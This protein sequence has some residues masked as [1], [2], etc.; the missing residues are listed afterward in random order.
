MSVDMKLTVPDWVADAIFYQIFPDRFCNGEKRNDPPGL[1]VWGD[2]PT[3]EN[4]FGGDL[5]GILIRLDYLQNL[6]VNALYLNPIFQARTNHRY[7]TIDY[8]KV[9]PA[10]G[11]TALLK[12]LV[13]QVH[14]RGMHIILDGVFNHCGDGFAPFQ[15]VINKG[16][17]SEYANWFLARS[18]PL[19]ID[20]LNFRTCGGC[21][22]LPKLNLA[23]RPVQEFILK[24]ACYW[25]EET[26]MDGWRLDVPFK[27][28]LDFWRKFRQ[29]VK[30]AN[31]Q[32]YLV[33]EVWREAAPWIAGDCFD[34][35]TNYRLRDLVLG[36]VLTHDFDGEDI[37]FELQTLLTA[38]GPA[39]QSMLNLLDSHDTP[40]ILTTLKGDIERLRIALT[41]QMT[42][43]GAPMIYYGDEVGLLGET[44]PDC[45][46]CMP[47]DEVDWNEKVVKIFHDLVILRREH[48]ALRY[49][50]PQSLTTFNFVFAY[51]QQFENDEVIIVLNP[52]ESVKALEIPI[53][54]QAVHWMEFSSRQVFTAINGTILFDQIPA[55]SAMVLLRA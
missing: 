27:I 50:D 52:R 3:R 7:D 33:G 44:D 36:Y 6:G 35:V 53:H 42:L 12:E 28:P 13:S 54:S 30:K 37:G 29:V 46:R 38:H 22:Y 9:D 45:R 49:G 48:H 32:A 21:T 1:A 23:H 24:V 4:F 47:W 2:P 11:D 10:L 25:L 34:G 18:Y 51:K 31:P 17:D 41:I 15:D 20:P 40:R 14:Q 19:S 16:S 5:K 8:F 43:P 55:C 26:G 39:A